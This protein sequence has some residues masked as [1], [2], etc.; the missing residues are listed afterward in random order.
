[1]ADEEEIAKL[2]VTLGSFKPGQALK[3]YITHVTLPKFKSIEPGTRVDFEFPLTALVG[4]NGIGKSSLL[5]ALWGMPFGYSTHK[6][7]FATALDPIAHSKKDPQR[8]FYGH[9]NDSFGGVVE[10][11]K[12]RLGKKADYWE[13]YR[14]SKQDGMKPLPAGQFEGKS[15]DRWNP[16]KRK[17]VYVNL[18]ATFG[19]FDRYFYFEDFDKNDEMR[20]VM[21]LEAKRLKSIKESHKASYRLGGGPE[22]LFENRDLTPIELGEVSKILG[23]TYDSARLIR[24]SLYPGAR[25]RDT[26]VVFERGAEYSEAF[27]GSGEIAAV[28]VVVDILN[29]EPYSLIL[30][31]E[32]ETSLHPGAQRALLRFLLEQIKVKK[33]Q[34]VLS[35]HSPEFLGGLPHNAIKVFEDNGKLQA[36]VLPKSSPSAALLRLGKVPDSKIRV[37]VEDQLA[38]LILRHAMKALDEGDAARVETTVSPG[39]GDFMLKFS[40]P[41]FMDAD[42]P[43]FILLD[44]DKRKVEVFTD[45]QTIPPAQHGTLSEILKNELGMDP[46]LNIPGGADAAGHQ[47]AKLHAQINYLSWVRGHVAYFPRKLPEH[48]VLEA[49]EPA[50]GHAETARDPAKAALVH[51]LTAGA[52]VEEV[53]SSDI[54]AWAK[55]KIATIPA[56]NADMISIRGQLVTWLALH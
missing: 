23:R 26:S 42:Q 27:A 30:L 31:D 16:V 24:H 18:K 54:L 21:Q 32:P 10:T 14:L 3:H 15:A 9:W 2:V 44:G 19:S 35:T 40:G 4:A 47:L 20:R 13:P 1:M 11:R 51:L 36:R 56:A 22:R 48:I 33:H 17:V 29:A 43:V 49:F 38:E 46:L 6:F 41:T 8:Y 25:G 28:R 45:P 7:W 53:S 50:Q 5:H 52:E 37:L 12:A 55:L 39:G 34:V